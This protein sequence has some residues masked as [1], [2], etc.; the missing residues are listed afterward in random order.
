MVK[1]RPNPT[2]SG[3]PSSASSCC[4]RRRL[5]QPHLLRRPCPHLLRPRLQVGASLCAHRAFHRARPRA[6]IATAA[7]RAIPDAGL[8]AAAGPPHGSTAPSSI[9]ADASNP[10][11]PPDR[12]DDGSIPGSSITACL[13]SSVALYV[14]TSRRAA[15]RGRRRS[16]LWMA[17]L[18]PAAQVYHLSLISPLLLHVWLP[19]V[20]SR[21]RI[22]STLPALSPST[23]YEIGSFVFEC[24]VFLTFE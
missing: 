19:Y 11:S 16:I 18:V 12:Q 5:P 8:S 1:T 15:G 23:L 9:C 17:L 10:P 22:T 20:Q 2:P 14:R 21:S 6:S 13:G 3:P 4:P 24:C 7:H